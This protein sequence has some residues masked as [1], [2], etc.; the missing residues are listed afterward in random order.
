MIPVYKPWI[1]ELEK[2]YVA[3]AMEST[4]ISSA[5][6]YIDLFEDLFAEYIGTKY[7]ISI[8]NGTSACHLALLSSGIG[9][10]DEVII[11]SCTFIATANAVSYCRAT[12]VPVDVDEDTWNF[13]L[14]NIIKATT[15]KTKAVFAVHLFGNPC[16]IEIRDWCNEN[17]ILYIEDACE[18]IGASYGSQKT[19]STGVCAAF[20]FFGNKN[21]T[22]GE[23]GMIT[24]DSEEIYDRCKYLKGQAQSGRYIHGDVGYNYR[25]TNIQAAIGCAQM[26]RID[27]ITREKK[28]VF[29]TYYRELESFVVTQQIRD[30]YTHANWIFPIVSDKKEQIE[31]ALKRN[32]IDTRPIFYPI[33]EMSPY[34]TNKKFKNSIRINRK[35][36]M[37]PSYP[38]LKEET[39]FKICDIVKSSL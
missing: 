37:L 22:T 17:N 23:G 18:S 1:T 4:W 31:N 15:E 33:N 5:G 8:N 16:D 28:R 19:G 36:L 39:I 6:K 34:K 20:S 27:E 2:D 3:D 10:G 7:A 30:G 24:T 9:L 29:D 12:P 35:G 38:E 14:D 25:M 32:S 21:L 26:Q 11:P 13:S